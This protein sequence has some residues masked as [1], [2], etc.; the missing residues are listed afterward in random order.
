MHNL[1]HVDEK[2]FYVT[3]VKKKFYVFPEEVLPKRSAKSKHF[4]TKVMFLDAVCR[5]RY[6]YHNEC[7]FDSKL[8]V[9]PFVEKV[10]AKRGSKNRPRGT[11]ETVPQSVT[12]DV[13]KD[14]VLSKDI[15]AIQAK[16]PRGGQLNTIYLQQ[17]NAS[18]HRRVTTKWLV[19]NGIPGIETTSQ[20][21]NSPDFNVLDLGFFNSIQSL[22]HRKLTRTIDEHIDAVESSF[23]K[24]PSSTLSKTFITL[25]KVMEKALEAKG[26]NDF[27]LPHMKKD[28]SIKELSTFN[29][30]CN[31]LILE[32]AQ[33]HLDSMESP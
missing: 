24:L 4:I 9:W 17:D 18:P 5:P 30:I 16:Y 25:Q 8:G 31:P 2:W 19:E 11:V 21:P 12:S 20:P 28:A 6:D 23:I 7:M 1:V 14:M 22:Q 13:Y 26:G 10:V 32:S 15:P 3:K 29:V 27:Q 33:K